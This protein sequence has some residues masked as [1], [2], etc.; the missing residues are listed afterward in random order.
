MVKQKVVVV[1][2]VNEE[3]GEKEDFR[4]FLRRLR[5]KYTDLAHTQKLSIFV[6]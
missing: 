2:V 5:A 6:V 3:Q 4:E 1:F